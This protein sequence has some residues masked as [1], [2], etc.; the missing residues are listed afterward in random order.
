MSHSSLQSSQSPSKHTFISSLKHTQPETQTKCSYLK[1]LL[2]RSFP[3]VRPSVHPSVCLSARSDSLLHYRGLDT[4]THTALP[5]IRVAS[6]TSIRVAALTSIRVA[7][8]SQQAKKSWGPWHKQPM[9]YPVCVSVSDSSRS[10]DPQW[11]Q[12]DSRDRYNTECHD[13][14]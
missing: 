1:P 6:L 4:H 2:N 13:D 11:Q 10:T 12:R 8:R 7:A 5:S 3:R 9:L 14:P